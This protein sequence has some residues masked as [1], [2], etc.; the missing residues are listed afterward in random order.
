[1]EVQWLELCASTARDLGLIPGW[2]TEIPQAIALQY[3]CDH[4]VLLFATPGTAAHEAPLSMGFS[5]QEFWSE[6]PFPSPEDLPDPGSGLL[7]LL[8]WQVGS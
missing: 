1:M 4:C 8:L 6:L 2:G 5:R 7:C 3:T